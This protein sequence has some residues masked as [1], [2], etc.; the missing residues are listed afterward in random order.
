[1]ED[2]FKSKLNSIILQNNF[3]CIMAKAIAQ[4]GFFKT[5][6]IPNLNKESVEV[7]LKKL[8]SFVSE[9]KSRNEKLSSCAVVI[10]DEN[11]VDFESFEKSFWSFLKEMN[12]LD[13]KTYKPDPTVD[14]DPTSSNFSYSIKEESFFI[15][16]LHPKSPRW[17][18]RFSYP[19]IV[20]NP[21]K[22]F[23]ELRKKG[24]FNKIRDLIRVKDK[25]LQGTENK[26][27]KNFGEK[28]EVYQYL[29]KD[30]NNNAPIPLSF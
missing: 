1:M 13:K 3:P 2:V 12:S 25:L 23:T 21:H 7:A 8:Q 11:L 4:K 15:I 24:T 10:Q 9:M 28:S 30:Y 6:S 5:F 20:F 19:T 16:A 26:M 18:R 22:Q 29:G 17:A 14:A 27:L